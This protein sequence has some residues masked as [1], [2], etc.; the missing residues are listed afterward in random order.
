[1]LILSLVSFTFFIALATAKPPKLIHVKENTHDI[2]A[3]MYPAI[4]CYHSQNGTM[5]L[6]LFK[7][8]K[9]AIPGMERLGVTVAEV[10]CSQMPKLCRHQGLKKTPILR[11]YKLI[12]FF[13]TVFYYTSFVSFCSPPLFQ[14]VGAIITTLERSRQAAF[15]NGSISLKTRAS[16][17]SKRLKR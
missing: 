5:G 17:S 7:A 10:N 16:E 9:E 15:L 8:F 2:A 6:D 14:V 4:L 12:S 3:G 1:M 13:P 11:F